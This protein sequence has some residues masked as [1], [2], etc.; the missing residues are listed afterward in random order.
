MLTSSLVLSSSWLDAVI[1]NLGDLGFLKREARGRPFK[2]GRESLPGDDQSR[3]DRARIIGA[4]V[5]VCCELLLALVN[6]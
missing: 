4:I 3:V 6:G 2:G 5:C 1:P